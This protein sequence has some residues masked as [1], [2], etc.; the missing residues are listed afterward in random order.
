[1]K[2]E[3]QTLCDTLEARGGIFKE[4]MNYLVRIHKSVTTTWKLYYAKK[5]KFLSSWRI[6]EVGNRS[7]KSTINSRLRVVY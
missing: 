1:M 3:N 5:K 4:P 2:S 6:R 7:L